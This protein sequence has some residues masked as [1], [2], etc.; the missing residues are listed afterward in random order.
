M[1]LKSSKR[2][3][4]W[5]VGDCEY[6]DFTEA[7]AWLQA[8]CDCCGPPDARTGIPIAIAILQSR[9]GTVTAPDVETLHRQAPLARLILL[10]GA[11]CDGELRTGRL[12]P[13][14]VRIRWH[15]WQQVLPAEL[16]CRAPSFPRTATDAERL[17]RQIRDLGACDNSGGRIAIRTSLRDNYLALADACNALGWRAEWAQA[18]AP[19]PSACELELIDGWKELSAHDG[20]QCGRALPRVLLIEY[21]RP[22]DFSRATALGIQAIVVRPFSLPVLM[23]VCAAAAPALAG[24]AVPSV[25]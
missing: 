12:P 19:L 3:V 14:V 15:Q 23:A 25:A 7:V 5:P 20:M 22:D 18:E 24:S 1:E 6:P 16:S 8:N 21:P 13:G 2:P 4:V 17:E 11:W 10:T 9:P